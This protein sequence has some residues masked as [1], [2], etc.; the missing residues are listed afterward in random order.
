MNFI[1]IILFIISL[2]TVGVFVCKYLKIKKYFWHFFAV[3]PVVLFLVI[4][5]ISRF[6]TTDETF[7]VLENIYYTENIYS[8]W[9][10]GALRFTETIFRPIFFVL[11]NH[12]DIFNRVLIQK[13]LHMYVGLILVLVL[14]FIL[15][16]HFLKIRDEFKLYCV[17][18][19]FYMVS[20]FMP[21]NALAFK[22]SNYDLFSMLLM[23]ISLVFLSIGIK[24]NDFNYSVY[25]LIC[26]VLAAQEKLTASPVIALSLIV[27]TYLIYKKYSKKVL[28]PLY[29]IIGLVIYYLV[30]L[31]MYLIVGLLGG[32]GVLEFTFY[33]V[34]YHLVSWGYFFVRHLYQDHTQVVFENFAFYIL[35]VQTFISATFL[36]LFIFW[37]EKKKHFYTRLV[38]YIQA[39]SEKLINILLIITFTLGIFGTFFVKAY[40]APYREIP[41][42]IYDPKTA[43]FNGTYLYFD[44]PDAPH[45]YFNSILWSYAVFV[46][47]IPTAV[48]L[49]LLL[50]I[51]YQIRNKKPKD[52][53][54]EDTLFLYLKLALI[55]SL[56]VPLIFTITRT[57]ISN[58]YL[59]VFSYVLGVYSV[60]NF[61]QII[62]FFKEKIKP[63]LVIFGIYTVI[64][65]FLVEVFPFKP[66][67]GAFRPFWSF[68]SK[69]YFTKVE[70]GRV[71]LSW[72]GWGEDLMLAGDRIFYN[73]EVSGE[74]CRNLRI[75]S[76]YN[77]RW[78]R[79]INN[80]PVSQYFEL[81]IA[82]LA[83]GS[84]FIGVYT[85]RD[86]FI[87]SRSGLIQDYPKYPEGVEPEFTIDYRGYTVAWVFRGDKLKDAGVDF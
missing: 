43:K 73:C 38:D 27:F 45:F 35:I 56:F 53:K 16:K 39:N 26:S 75:F 80:L 47:S 87:L 14:F 3:F 13:S 10:A 5:R 8:Q 69:D 23:L 71:D 46:N 86:Y 58:R 67:F 49:I 2:C 74:N 83:P 25:G 76:N 51:L 34:S 77:G 48:F 24:K 36:I 44:V 54:E 42:N 7:T 9:N 4:E 68:Q 18:T 17:F 33:S 32:F 79:K 50:K 22:V 41:A 78:M 55:F 59:N 82:G 72:M 64:I 1:E 29:Y 57:P 52:V 30:T 20:L 81:T 65:L 62:D 37:L 66:V 31:F 85:N 28:L 11:K 61:L 6:L 40:W 12:V 19:L 15:Q 70:K 63:D 60:F 84:D 21:M